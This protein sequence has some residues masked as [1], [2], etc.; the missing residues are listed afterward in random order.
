MQK[1]IAIYGA[2]G[3]GREV[4]CMLEVINHQE[5]NPLNSIGFF[6]DGVAPATQAGTHGK[7]LGDI[8]TLNDWPTPLCVALCFG[9][10]RTIAAVRAKITNP[11]VSFPNLIY[12]DF[13]IAEAATFTIGEGNI[14]TS[15]CLATCN[16]AVGDFNLLNGDVVLAHDVRLGNYNCIMPGVRVSGEVTIGERNLIGSCSF[17]LQQTRIGNEVT[18]SPGS[19]LLTNPKDGNTYIGNPAKKFKY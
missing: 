17:I 8:H 15:G 9:N 11:G 6:D 13:R 2:G 7:V 5:G 10:P 12:P 1:D 19:I 14:I 18:L 16:V 3:L 4:A